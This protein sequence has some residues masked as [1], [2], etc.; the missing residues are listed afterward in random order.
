MNQRPTT[1]NHSSASSTPGS[2]GAPKGLRTAEIYKRTWVRVGTGMVLLLLL[3]LFLGAKG[4]LWLR[5]PDTV[6]P[7]DG[8]IF[9]LVNQHSGRCLSVKGASTAPGAGIIQGPTPEGAR[10]S[11]R[12]ILLQVSSGVF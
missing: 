7:T 8:R 5:K 4:W 10:A 12:W 9:L 2:K 1:G 6:E 3:L 11:E